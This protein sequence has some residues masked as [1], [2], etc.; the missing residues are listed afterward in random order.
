M[1]SG[2]G[3]AVPKLDM[4]WHESERN[5]TTWSLNALKKRKAETFSLETGA[6]V[7][8]QEMKEKD[9]VDESKP[10]ASFTLSEKV[11]TAISKLL[12]LMALLRSIYDLNIRNLVKEHGD[13]LEEN[14]TKKCT[15][16]PPVGM[17][18]LCCWEKS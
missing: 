14:L 6:S 11:R 15:L 7:T 17:A 12:K 8:I 3:W 18:W 13:N 16:G 10:A 4:K 1:F 5:V 9:I 2:A